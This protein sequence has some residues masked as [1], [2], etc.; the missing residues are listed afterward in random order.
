MATDDFNR[1][2]SATLGGDW[3]EVENASDA[4]AIV[5]NQLRIR[6]SDAALSVKRGWMGFGDAVDDQ[7]SQLTLVSELLASRTSAG[8]GIRMS[9][10]TASFTGYVSEWNL[11]ISG[12]TI[13]KYVSEDINTGGTSIAENDFTTKAPGDVMKIEAT[14]TTIKLYRNSVE[15]I[16]VTD[17]AIASGRPGAWTRDTSGIEYYDDWDDWEGTSGAVLESGDVIGEKFLTGTGIE[18]PDLFGEKFL[19]GTAE[20]RLLELT[21]SLI[22]EKFLLVTVDPELAGMFGEKFLIGTDDLVG[23]VPTS[24]FVKLKPHKRIIWKR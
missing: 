11:G 23:A 14:G 3:T 2:D 12:W 9:G 10:T 16:S 24:R 5:S 13:R 7:Y 18:F 6:R 15:I 17:S 19:G 8:P 20:L 21:G 1:V 22:G 4:F